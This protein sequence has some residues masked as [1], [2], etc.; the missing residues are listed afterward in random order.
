MDVFVDG[1][2]VSGN[3]TL[4]RVT[5]DVSCKQMLHDFLESRASNYI[6]LLESTNVVMMCVKIR[7]TMHGKPASDD[8]FLQDCSVFWDF[9]VSMTMFEL[10]AKRRF[11]FERSRHIEARPPRIDPMLVMMALRN[12]GSLRLPPV[13]T[14]V[15]M[16]GKDVL[17][18]DFRKYL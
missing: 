4:M 15:V 9:P 17:Y 8:G 3:G 5:L 13:R 10:S 11:T 16:S 14:R 12:I 1:K 2:R 7:D 18:N 6:P